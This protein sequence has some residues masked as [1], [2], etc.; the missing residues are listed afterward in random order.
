MYAFPTNSY[1]IRTTQ[2]LGT[3]LASFGAVYFANPIISV[4]DLGIATGTTA[5]ISSKGGFA[6]GGVY[7]G[8]LS[9]SPPPLLSGVCTEF[10]VVGGGIRIR[11]LQPAL[12][13]TGRIY[14]ACVPVAAGGMID[15]G[16]MDV[17]AG[18]SNTGM[19]S[20]LFSNLGLPSPALCFS[21]AIQAL[22]LASDFV[23]SSLIEG[24]EIDVNFQVFHPALYNFKPALTSNV[25]ANGFL[26]TDS[27]SV[28]LA[29][30]AVDAR[31]VP[32]ASTQCDG[33]AAIIVYC[34]GFPTSGVN[35]EVDIIYHLETTPKLSANATSS[36]SGIVPTPDGAPAPCCGSSM[37]VESVLAA[38]NAPNNI[39]KEVRTG[40]AEAKKFDDKYLGGAGGT[41]LKH[42][43]S[44]ALKFMLV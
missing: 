3:G 18:G 39:I 27:A 44:T 32:K 35:I 29:T 1:H 7:T 6:P 13:G 40:L 43:I 38:A 9:A 17:V 22:P 10:R 21:P 34:E 19:Y 14:V 28:F 24:D 12:T 33:S 42:G 36:G 30:G 16:A 25:S 26:Y 41:A 23:V 37:A 2:L 20:G 8:L 15:Y 11:N 5:S 4:A 31:S